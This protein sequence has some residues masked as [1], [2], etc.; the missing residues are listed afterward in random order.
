[1]ICANPYDSQDLRL[2][3]SWLSRPQAKGVDSTA[4]E[5]VSTG[6]DRISCHCMLDR[7]SR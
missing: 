1:V 3:R 4:V 7:S 5:H 6:Y 2:N